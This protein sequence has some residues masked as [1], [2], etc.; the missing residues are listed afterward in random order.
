MKR[1]FAYVRV[2]G[3]E[4]NIDR[5][6]APLAKLGVLTENIFIDYQSGKDFNRPAYKRLIRKLKNG[7]LLIIHSIDRL[8][9]N[10][11]EIIE[12]WRVITKKLQADIIVLDMP[13]LDTTQHRD[14]LGT[15]ISDLVLQI[16]SYVAH[17]ERETILLR[18]AEGIAE[19]K[20]RGVVFGRPPKPKPV[21]YEAIKRD[22]LAEIINSR[23][24]A[25]LSNVSQKTFLKWINE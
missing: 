15:L 8:G 2:S 23:K 13:L 1:K 24:A 16:L 22:Y 25:R 5:Q 4:Q 20:K 21:N 3:S 19:A 14:L 12:Q 18:Q 11:K 17:N 6:L 9:R 10:Y 7:D